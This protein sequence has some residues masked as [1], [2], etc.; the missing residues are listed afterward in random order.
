MTQTT[1]QTTAEAPPQVDLTTAIQRVLAE[2]SEPLT[3]AKIRSH[4]PAPYRGVALE[5]LGEV[6][7]RQAAANVLYEFPKYRSKQERY[8]DRPMA[9]H[10]TALVLEALGEGPLGASELRRKLPVYAV[11]HAEAVLQEQVS[12]GKIHRHPRLGKRGKERMGVRPA[13]AK[14]YLRS[15]LA[16]LFREL[17]ELGFTEAQLREGAIE[18]LHEEEWSPMTAPAATEEE[19]REQHAEGETPAPAMTATPPEG[20]RETAESRGA[21]P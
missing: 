20:A 13:D 5:E 21:A 7:K 17:A 14:D 18:L 15:E 16:A 3:L 12:L 11:A 19:T 8:W 1:D 9:V 2:S 10:V 4:L 6:L